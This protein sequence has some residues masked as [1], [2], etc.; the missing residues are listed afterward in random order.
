[1]NSDIGTFRNANHKQIPLMINPIQNRK[2]FKNDT[3][4]TCPFVIN[5]RPQTYSIETLVSLRI[6]FD[7]LPSQRQSVCLRWWHPIP[8]VRLL[9]RAL[10]GLV[11]LGVLAVIVGSVC[12]PD[13]PVITL[14]SLQ[15][16]VETEGDELCARYAER[17]VITPPPGPHGSFVCPYP[18]EP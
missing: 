11:L 6:S 9:R 12:G 10:R 5:L 4:K 2:D 13:E 1:M 16:Q 7:S 17:G 8:A 15:A 3:L 14:E 18:P